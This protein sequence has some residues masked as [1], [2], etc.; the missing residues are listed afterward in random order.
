[1]FLI[2]CVE[3]ESLHSV[4]TRTCTFFIS[5]LESDFGSSLIKKKER[6]G[7]GKFCIRLPRPSISFAVRGPNATVH[8]RSCSSGH[9]F[10]DTNSHL[11]GPIAFSH[12]AGAKA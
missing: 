12:Y 5:V 2:S 8:E 10:F 4:Q 11:Q 3:V 6:C 9:L 1:M 7:K